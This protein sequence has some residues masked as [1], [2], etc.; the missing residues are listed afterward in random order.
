MV[1]TSRDRRSQSA[2][3]DWP[4]LPTNSHLLITKPSESRALECFVLERCEE[5]AHVALLV[6]V[7]AESKTV[8]SGRLTDLPM[9]S[10]LSQT[11]W[12]LQA[13]LYDL[14]SN[15]HTASF[16]ICKRVYNECQRILYDDPL[17]DA[18]VS[19][20]PSVSG[21][22]PRAKKIISSF[23][24][25][26]QKIFPSN[27]KS[28]LVGMGAVLASVPA[29]PLLAQFSGQVAVEQ[30]RARPKPQPGQEK[31]A[32]E[33]IE[34][35][36]DDED[37]SYA[38]GFDDD[39]SDDGQEVQSHDTR[40]SSRTVVSTSSSRKG[41]HPD[42]P[43]QRSETLPAGFRETP[44]PSNKTA[45]VSKGKA[46]AAKSFENAF[47]S[48]TAGLNDI[49]DKA[50]LA[51]GD[52]VGQTFGLNS[53][54][55][56]AADAS[57]AP[58]SPPAWHPQQPLGKRDRPSNSTRGVSTPLSQRAAANSES[59]PNLNVSRT[60]LH[61]FASSVT[62]PDGNVASV[63]AVLA[64][65]DTEARRRLLRSNYCRT[66]T[67]F[68]LG[69][70]DISARLLLLPKPARLS[71]LR[72]EL[73]ALN[74]RLPA[75]VCFPLWCAATSE[76]GRAG[77]DSENAIDN[78]HSV[79]GAD[80]AESSKPSRKAGRK[81]HRVVRINPSE[82]VVLNSADRA[83]YL[84]HVEVLSDDLD[85]DPE[86]RS[87]RD[88][89][90]KLVIAEDLRRRKF[91]LSRAFGSDSAAASRE[92]LGLK[93]AS[94]SKSEQRVA[95]LA[96]DGTSSSSAAPSPV[97]ASNERMESR[98][99]L[100]V[101]MPSETGLTQEGA[102]SP[103]LA[104]YDEGVDLTEQA[105]GS[106]LAGFGEEQT[107]D[108]DE[109]DNLELINRTHDAAAWI[110][111]RTNGGNAGSSSNGRHSR[112][113]SLSGDSSAAKR[114]D[115]S[116]DEYSERMRTAAIMLAQLNQSTN[117][118][119]QPAVTHNPHVS[120]TAQGGWSSWIVGTSWASSNS[121]ALNKGSEVGQGSAGVKS[122]VTSGDSQPL[123][124]ALSPPV[125]SIPKPLPSS[126]SSGSAPGAAAGPSKLIHADTES[127][128]KRIMH[129]MMLLE[130]ERM[131]RM[132]SGSRKLTSRRPTTGVEDEATVLRAVS[133]DDPSA[134]IFK[135]TW[136]SKKARI[137]ANS[138]YGH[139]PNW[140]VFSVIVKT[141]ADLRQEQLAVQLVNE[142]GRIW[143]EAKSPLWVRYF[144]ILVTS[145][146][147]GLMETVTDAIS[148]HSIKKEAYARAQ[149]DQNES[150]G[151]G[152]PGGGK[153]ATYSIFDHFVNTYG[154]PSSAKFNRARARFME[155]LAGY[156]I[157]SY[158]LQIKDRHN[159]NI[160]LSNDGRIIHID[161]GFMLG[162]SPGG[163][164]FEAAPFKLTQEYI[165]ILGGLDSPGFEQ[166]RQ[167]MRQ[168][169]KDV[170]KHAERIIMVVELMQKGE[171]AP[172]REVAWILL[173]ADSARSYSI[174][175]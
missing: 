9:R 58:K 95:S 85:F 103:Q 140:D 158:L 144:R 37:D 73:T 78:T 69:L 105:F 90:K 59:V 93:D 170:R 75:E 64:Q 169:F 48:L 163:V 109:E 136:A 7:L 156:S 43:P 44:G 84:L 5:S 164:G 68:L 80:T 70:Q 153:I 46:P 154:D 26:K 147:S 148:V 137:R 124:G 27:A 35:V 42:G 77:D 131:E 133:K 100:K 76:G 36:N 3:T 166:F 49:R 151:G 88:S 86:R 134:A 32:I 15:P 19:L 71:A 30:G 139:L 38:E 81:H 50:S 52:A 157:V 102:N 18:N 47:A 99:Q 96:Q 145:E 31:A 22:R 55:N 12:H 51:V 175:T 61:G 111:A 1:S 87:N 25:T 72:A 24:R 10:L 33:G 62:L 91:A 11:L 83:P 89:L 8:G 112:Q 98:P 67:E 125:L 13:A 97:I 2:F 115:F 130:E 45:S 173:N 41:Q 142:F 4:I 155:S 34:D 168:G 129:E 14:S 150:Q 54:T 28:T 108:E 141:G 119:G 16:E 92:G 167:L 57:N 118:G 101:S 114:K 66:Q 128:R 113:A 94:R 121:G 65:Y 160:L 82:A 143:T 162:I 40:A 104:D 132:K 53:P 74:H 117:A 146:N 107:R 63:D 127:I 171:F 23:A 138:P 165:D 149:R 126:S 152:P 21:G 39:D 17:S 172:R 6:S 56:K 20:V 110:E 122:H 135:E 106:D 159:G 174:S 120:A 79:P 60:S 116:L 123:G 29:M 161:F